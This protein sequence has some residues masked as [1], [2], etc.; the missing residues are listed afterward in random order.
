MY[1]WGTSII[2]VLYDVTHGVTCRKG[3]SGLCIRLMII[4][5]RR[6]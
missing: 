4:S 1:S 5:R 3:L 6:I 2:V